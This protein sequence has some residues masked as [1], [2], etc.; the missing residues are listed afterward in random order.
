MNFSAGGDPAAAERDEQRLKSCLTYEVRLCGLTTNLDHKQAFNEA[1]QRTHSELLNGLHFP[2]TALGDGLETVA[3]KSRDAF[4]LI[5][6][7]LRQLKTLLANSPRLDQPSLSSSK[8]DTSV[9]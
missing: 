7:P 9:M 2:L 3:R 5:K 8:A 6:M 4:A 1:G